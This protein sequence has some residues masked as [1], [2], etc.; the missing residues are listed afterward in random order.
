LS[1]RNIT[2]L[3]SPIC[4]IFTSKGV[5][6]RLCPDPL[7]EL[8]ALPSYLRVDGNGRRKGDKRKSGQKGRE[9]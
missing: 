5:A 2:N 4:S 6:A 7:G 9:G 8:I 1:K 3:C